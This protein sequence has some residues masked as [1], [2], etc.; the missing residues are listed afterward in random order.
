M[1]IYAVF[2]PTLCSLFLAAAALGAASK[3]PN[4]IFIVADDLGHG[5]VGFN[6]CKD[7]PTPNLDAMARNGVRF[8]QAYAAHPFCS[9]TRASIMAGRYQQRFGHELNTAFKPDDDKVGLPVTETL[10]P[11]ILKDA[12]YATG[13]VGKWHL[14]FH[15]VFHPNQRGFDE[16]FGFLGGGHKYFAPWNGTTEMT[17]PLL[18]NQTPVDETTPY[19]TDVF[20]REAVAFITRHAEK[21]FFLYLAYNAP[22]SPVNAPDNYVK[23][24]VKAE[25][26]G[27]RYYGAT[28]C[29]MDD[30][31]GE[32]MD[33]LKKL[34]IEEKT[35]VFFLSDNGGAKESKCDNSPFKG[36]KAQLYEGGIHVPF[37]AQWRGTFPAGA[38]FDHPVITMDLF[39]TAVGL[40]NGKAPNDRPMDGVNLAPYVLGQTQGAPHDFL[41]WR[42]GGGSAYAVRQGPWKLVLNLN[43]PGGAKGIVQLGARHRRNQEPGRLPA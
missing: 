8:S 23:R 40:A 18:R 5:D 11:K 33:T 13:L 37:L 32:I 41:F 29:A 24:M 43:K 34:R 16:F 22:H 2:R 27:R 21:P 20:N 7:I 31:V 19:I 38:V 28:I 3:Q 39:A 25:N 36:L 12:G 26:N 1:T 42:I 9:P 35:L 15:P 30:G 4:L 10:L 6:G 14:G 17:T